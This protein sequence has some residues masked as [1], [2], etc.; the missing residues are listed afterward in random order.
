MKK[1]TKKKLGA[2]KGARNGI[3]KKFVNIRTDE[4]IV[5]KFKQHAVLLDPRCG[6]K[7]LFDQF[8]NSLP[9]V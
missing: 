6:Q 4:T 5:D 3:P 1:E 2:P 9:D 8:V 7:L